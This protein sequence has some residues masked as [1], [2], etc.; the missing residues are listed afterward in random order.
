MVGGFLILIAMSASR[1]V[2]C[3][4]ITSVEVETNL[5]TAV[6]VKGH[7]L[8]YTPGLV[9]RSPKA[10]PSSSSSSLSFCRLLFISQPRLTSAASDTARPKPC[11]QEGE[12]YGPLGVICWLLSQYLRALCRDAPESDTNRGVQTRLVLRKLYT[13]QMQTLSRADTLPPRV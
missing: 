3:P 6:S 5:R 11:V 9:K 13:T 12:I 10:P 4:P 8:N 2:C 7:D 1:L